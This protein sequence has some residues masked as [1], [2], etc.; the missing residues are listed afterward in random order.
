M[1]L[2]MTNSSEE[3]REAFVFFSR[4][5]KTLDSAAVEPLL[6][7]LGYAPTTSEVASL[8]KT[9]EKVYNGSLTYPALAK[10][11]TTI[12]D[13][14]IGRP[15]QFVSQMNDAFAAYEQLCRGRSKEEV[16]GRIKED[17]LRMLLTRHGDVLEPESFQA[18]LRFAG[19]ARRGDGVDYRTLTS[20]L[21]S[22]DT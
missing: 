2:M 21:A 5:G 3:V 8:I 10:L 16:G 11:I 22:Q 15:F 4:D 9:V 17:D 1:A 20:L 19:E 18:L 12:V 13:P 7:C 14:K 6:R